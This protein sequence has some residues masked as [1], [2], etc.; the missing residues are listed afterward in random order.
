MGHQ[1]SGEDANANQQIK[2]Q[3]FRAIVK[4]KQVMERP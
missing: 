2:N 1:T 3:A 4:E